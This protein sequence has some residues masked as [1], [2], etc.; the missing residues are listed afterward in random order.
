MLNSE[1]GSDT[2]LV[3]CR[4]VGDQATIVIAG[5]LDMT[6]SPQITAAVEQVLQRPVNR[7]EIDASDL[8]FIDSA[9]LQSLLVA[10]NTL[11]A[12]DVEFRLSAMSQ[13]VERVIDMACVR[14]VLVPGPGAGDDVDSAPPDDP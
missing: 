8:S 6:G 14:D 1:L 10:R 3:S 7:V 13:A 11:H 5:E 9:G 12:A 4:Y 2:A